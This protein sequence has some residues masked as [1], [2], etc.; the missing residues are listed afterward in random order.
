MADTVLS[1]KLMLHIL[2]RDA[3]LIISI[4]LSTCFFLFMWGAWLTDKK[5][6]RYKGIDGIKE[7]LK[8]LAQSAF[9]SLM[10]FGA[11]LY[12]L[13]FLEK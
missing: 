2:S 13:Q 5:R 12:L 3:V 10:I 6:P 8:T 9:I 1:F 7:F 11:L 4:S